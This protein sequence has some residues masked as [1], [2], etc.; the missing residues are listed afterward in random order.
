MAN[1]P[2][3]YD[4]VFIAILAMDVYHR[5]TTDFPVGQHPGLLVDTPILGTA[6]AID[7]LH[8][9]SDWAQIGFFAQAYNWEGRTVIAYRG[10]DEGFVGTNDFYYGFG[11]SVG[12]PD[13]LQARAAI[14]F[15]KDA[16]SSPFHLPSCWYQQRMHAPA[17]CTRAQAPAIWSAAVWTGR[18]RREPISGP[19]PPG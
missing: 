15:Y 12:D 11:V 19:S 17:L 9:D 13:T 10:T 4:D 3:T 18:R 2:V 6:T 5:G 16:A 7:V 8:S 1:D 14:Q